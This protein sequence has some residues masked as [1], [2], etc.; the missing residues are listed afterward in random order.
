MLIWWRVW[1]CGQWFSR[2]LETI[3]NV[4]NFSASV[5]NF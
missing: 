1:L 4:H 5:G 3:P 2:S